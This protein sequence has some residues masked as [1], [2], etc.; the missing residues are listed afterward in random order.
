MRGSQGTETQVMADS[1]VLSDSLWGGWWWRGMAGKCY[2]NISLWRKHS[3]IYINYLKLFN[4]LTLSAYQPRV[5]CLSVAVSV[6]PALSAS[7]RLTF[8]CF[9]S[10][11]HLIFVYCAIEL[12]LLCHSIMY[13]PGIFFSWSLPFSSIKMSSMSQG[14]NSCQTSQFT[15]THLTSYRQHPN[16][17]NCWRE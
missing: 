7:Q 6:L 1:C 15:S 3:W 8:T 17:N 4:V 14:K 2:F 16:E 9:F 12:S 13:I 5:L 10:T 11:W